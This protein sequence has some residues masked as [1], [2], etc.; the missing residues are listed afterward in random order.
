M[1][2][3]ICCGADE[4]QFIT[5]S[6]GKRFCPY[7][8]NEVDENEINLQ[9][10]KAIRLSCQLRN[11]FQYSKALAVCKRLLEEDPDSP[12]YNWYALLANYKVTFIDNGN[13]MEA[14]FLDTNV[15][16]PITKSKYYSRLSDRRKKLAEKLQESRMDYKEQALKV[17][18]YDVFISYKKHSIKDAT[19]ETKEAKWANQLYHYLDKKGYKVFYD[20]EVLSRSNVEWEPHIYGAL[21]NAKMLILCG[22]SNENIEAQW[23][24]NEWKRFLA[25]RRLDKSKTICI[26]GL[27]IDP[28]KLSDP[29]L[30]VTQMVNADDGNWLMTLEGRVAD[31]CNKVTIKK[32]EVK[33]KKISERLIDINPTYDKEKDDNLNRINLNLSSL[34]K[35]AKAVQTYN[36]VYKA[37]YDT[38]SVSSKEIALGFVIKSNLDSID[39]LFNMEVFKS[40]GDKSI[41]S[42]ILSYNDNEDLMNKTISF[43]YKAILI[44]YNQSYAT[45][46]F[47]DVFPYKHKERTEFIKNL[48]P[49]ICTSQGAYQIFDKLLPVYDESK[50]DDIDNLV[51][52]ANLQLKKE[53]YDLALKYAKDI[54]DKYDKNNLRA[55]EIRLLAS[56]KAKSYDDCFSFTNVMDNL[57]P[58]NLTYLR[59]FLIVL[60]TNSFSCKK[61]NSKYARL[62]DGITYCCLKCQNQEIKYERF[63]DSITVL[64]TILKSILNGIPEPN[65]I[66]KPNAPR[67]YQG[68]DVI[69]R[70]YVNI[71]EKLLSYY[72]PEENRFRLPVIAE[73]LHKKALYKLATKYY[74]SSFDTGLL[75]NYEISYRLLLCDL[76]CLNTDSLYKTTRLV[77]ESQYYK[78]LTQ[79]LLPG[80]EEAKKLAEIV[81]KQSQFVKSK[82]ATNAKASADNDT[83]A[84]LI[85]RKKKKIRRN[86]LFTLLLIVIFFVVHAFINLSAVLENLI[87]AVGEYGELIMLI[88]SGI[89]LF[90][91]LIGLY[92]SRIL[93]RKFFGHTY[94]LILVAYLAFLIYAT[95][96]QHAI[97]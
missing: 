87:P 65:D 47:L 49:L 20:S 42:K 8:G 67:M 22:S 30:K 7:C 6:T 89:T 91:L 43:I 10:A 26:L 45:K 63:Y 39:E 34:S 5:D 66:D 9:A 13:G 14:T 38:N 25:Y 28:N 23:V 85:K 84:A 51:K 19:R 70:G 82:P 92:K 36:A 88:A 86:R 96:V 62:M 54:I 48:F 58:I 12:I 17:V 74:L 79:A 4:S 41:Y 69:N 50:E 31:A 71:I 90:S 94:R 60:G 27:N 18:D 59:D 81:Q 2:K 44:N 77:T 78:N 93:K 46:L 76:E 83:K 97:I 29:E 72:P 11:S 24:K 15:Q 56:N 68:I 3:C 73:G 61:C 75:K 64:D 1:S 52:Y 37:S 35:R 40:L 55:N 21:K 33:K 32:P 80:S 95:L 53:F 16:T 57:S